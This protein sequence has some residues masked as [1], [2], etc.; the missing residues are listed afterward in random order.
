MIIAELTKGRIT[1]TLH[2]DRV[3]VVSGGPETERRRWADRFDMANVA[4]DTVTRP[5]GPPG[6]L[7]WAEE[8]AGE[9]EMEMKAVYKTPKA[10]TTVY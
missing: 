7:Q 2:D 9:F 10:G 8:L 6:L 3:W 4:E 5:P 1:A